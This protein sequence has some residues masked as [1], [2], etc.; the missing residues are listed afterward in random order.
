MRTE[1]HA[2]STDPD[3]LTGVGTFIFDTHNVHVAFPTFTR[4]HTLVTL[5]DREMQNTAYTAR[6]HLKDQIASIAI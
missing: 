2:N 1:W 5:I 4:F 6:R 3:D